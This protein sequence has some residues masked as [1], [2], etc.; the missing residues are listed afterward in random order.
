MV[1]DGQFDGQRTLG[2]DDRERLSLGMVRATPSSTTS[3]SQWDWPKTSVGEYLRA[4]SD[5]RSP[6]SLSL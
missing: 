6:M 1:V 4:S 2:L 3:T 5:E